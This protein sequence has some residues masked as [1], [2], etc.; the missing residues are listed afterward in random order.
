MSRWSNSLHRRA[1]SRAICGSRGSTRPAKAARCRPTARATTRATSR[2][3]C[4]CGGSGYG[5]VFATTSNSGHTASCASKTNWGPTTYPSGSTGRNAAYWA[6]SNPCAPPTAPFA[7]SY[8]KP[9]NGAAPPLYKSTWPGY[10][11]CTGATGT[12]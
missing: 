8:S 2:P 1:A 9:A 11:W 6:C 12:A 3:S 10:S 4:R 7:S 5:C